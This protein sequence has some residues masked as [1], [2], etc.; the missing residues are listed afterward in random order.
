MTDYGACPL[1]RSDL[2]PIELP[3]Q[4]PLDLTASCPSS[5]LYAAAVETSTIIITRLRLPIDYYYQVTRLYFTAL[6]ELMAGRLGFLLLAEWAFRL[7]MAQNFY[8]KDD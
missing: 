1:L 2:R 7:L 8:S 3:K 4:R 6:N 5:S